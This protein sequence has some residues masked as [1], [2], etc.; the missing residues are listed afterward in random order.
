MEGVACGG[1]G[2]G[3]CVFFLSSLSLIR[4][5]VININKYII[6][7]LYLVFECVCHKPVVVHLFPLP[8]LAACR[9]LITEYPA[10]IMRGRYST[11]AVI[12]ST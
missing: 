1:E 7:F 11:P 4:C 8:L 5:C 12:R 6:Y 9:V 2:G 10:E 3:V